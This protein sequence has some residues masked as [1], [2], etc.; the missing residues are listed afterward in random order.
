MTADHRGAGSARDRPEHEADD[1]GVVGV[2]EHRHDVRHE[3]DRNREVA[4]QQP[5]PHTG[6]TGHAEVSG[7]AP[8]QPQEVGQ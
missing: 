6:G 3:V 4:E 7:Q 1:D 2:A 8:Q 5:E